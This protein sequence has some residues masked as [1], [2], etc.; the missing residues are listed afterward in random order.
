MKYYLRLKDLDNI[1]SQNTEYSTIMKEVL[2]FNNRWL[3]RKWVFMQKFKQAYFL[4]REMKGMKPEEVKWS[5]DCKIKCPH[6]ID[7][8]SFRAMMELHAVIKNGN[9]DSV[10]ELITE[11]ITI[12]CYK[13][14]NEGEYDSNSEKYKAFREK[15]SSE[16]LV[17]MMGLYNRIYKA[18]QDSNQLW[19]ERFLSVEIE[20]K[21]Y[22]QASGWRMNQFNVLTTVAAICNDFNV[23]YDKAWQ[24]SYN[25][26]QTNS[27]RKATQAHIQDQMRQIKEV[28]MK[29]ERDRKSLR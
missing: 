6:N 22:E 21:E 5:E 9:S 16:S 15:V 23:T 20:D 28:K 17:H 2:G 11:V 12:A 24:V 18:V 29:M 19:E 7:N 8:I 13:D 25:V 1:A 3:G 10:T 27:Y 14:N 26:T 4:V